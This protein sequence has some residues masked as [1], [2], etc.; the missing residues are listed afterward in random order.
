MSAFPY[1]INR[2]RAAP[3]RCVIEAAFSHVILEI[4]IRVTEP[5]E[6]AERG[7]FLAMD[8]VTWIEWEGTGKAAKQVGIKTAKKQGQK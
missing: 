7:Y 1:D 5:W 4:T 2:R 3:N 8:K 6:I